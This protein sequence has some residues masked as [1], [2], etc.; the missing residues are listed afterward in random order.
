METLGPRT[1]QLHHDGRRL[2][3][4]LEPA[5]SIR[6]Q[7]GWDALP[8]ELGIVCRADALD[9]ELAFNLVRRHPLSLL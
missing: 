5:S 4:C 8:P 7:L 3:V 9:D 6:D 2:L 1:W